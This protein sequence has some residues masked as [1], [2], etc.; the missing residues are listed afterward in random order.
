MNIVASSGWLEF[1]ADETN[2]DFFAGPIT[3]TDELL[4]ATI[5]MFEVFKR[6]I[7][8]RNQDDTLQAVAVMRQGKVINLDETLALQAAKFGHEFKL[9]LA[10]SIIFATA[11]AHG[12][13]LWTQDADFQGLEGVRYIKK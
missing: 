1:F 13:T 3:K 12:A 11:R 2:A 7:Q 6:I 5:N 9:P 8:Q 4:V 10:D